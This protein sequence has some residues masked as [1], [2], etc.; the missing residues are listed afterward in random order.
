MET[1]FMTTT[2]K[3]TK[4]TTVKPVESAV[5]AG[6][7]AVETAVKAGTEA[8]T[9]GFE[10]A[11]AVSK[12]QVE[13]AAKA[14]ADAFK[15]YEDVVTYNRNNMEALLKVSAIWAKGV[16][17]INNELTVLANTSMEQGVSATKQMMN[18]KTVEEVVAVQ[19]DLAKTSYDK[20]VVEG[21]KI[22]DMGIKLAETA[23]QPLAARVNETVATLSKPLA[24]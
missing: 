3:T 5:I 6:K 11:V 21:R 10:K 12:E 4:A 13:A 19:S 24:A 18:C 16:Q 8:A 14:G 17:D 2:K 23:A 1:K 22:S 7:E 9:Q 20:A 15:G